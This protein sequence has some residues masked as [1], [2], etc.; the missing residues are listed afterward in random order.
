MRRR[1]GG[2][3]Q[4]VGAGMLVLALTVA[5]PALSTAQQE[6]APAEDPAASAPGEGDPSSAPDTGEATD[7]VGEEITAAATSET[8]AAAPAEPPAQPSAKKAATEVVSV[9][10]NFYLPETVEIS[11]GDTITWRNDGAAP[12]TATADNGSFDTGTFQPGQSRSKSFSTAGT[13][14]YYCTIHGQ[15]QSGTIKVIA[16]S[17]GDGNGGGGGGGSGGGG[18][19][20][21]TSGSEA[22]AVSSPGAAGS[23]TSLPATGL[24]A[25]VLGA[26][27]L[28]LI[29]SGSALRRLERR[30]PR[31]RFFSL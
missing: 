26:I 27:G 29:S 2:R 12:H 24:A 11:V 19:T 1:A 8:S 31:G 5:A 20:A 16:S 14:P 7:P 21:A 17:S 18:G 28:G 23:S 13:I 9:G 25:I 4:M 10:D 30:R 15:A 3:L 22:A 6:P